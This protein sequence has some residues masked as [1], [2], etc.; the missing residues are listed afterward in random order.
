M[1]RLSNSHS[2]RNSATLNDIFPVE[3]R[4]SSQRRGSLSK[5]LR[6]SVVELQQTQQ[7]HLALEYSSK[8]KSSDLRKII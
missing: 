8:S 4:I 2:R 1:D 5:N 3:P 6:D 7:M